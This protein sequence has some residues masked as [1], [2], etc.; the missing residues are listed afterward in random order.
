[1]KKVL[2]TGANG[3]LGNNLVRVLLKRGYQVKAGVRHMKDA[4]L[5]E[6]LTCE[7]VH[8]DLLDKG[9]LKEAL[10]GVEVLYQVAAVYKHW[11]CNPEEDIINANQ[12]GTKNILE[13]AKEAGVHQV[14]Y[15]S[16]V[17]ALEPT[18][19]NQNGQIHTDTWCEHNHNH[20]YI[21]SKTKSEKLAHKLSKELG[22]NL[23]A[24]LP[25]SMMGGIYASK[26]TPTANIC[27]S[28]VNGTTGFTFDSTI[29]P[30]CVMDVA[31]AMVDASEVG[32]PG[33]RYILAPERPVTFDRMFEI[34]KE[35][36]PNL[37]IPPK[38]DYSSLIQLAQ[39][40][41]EEAL[42]E[43]IE[44]RLQVCNINAYYGLE[45]HY[46]I[47]ASRKD[48]GFVYKKPETVLRDYFKL[49][50]HQKEAFYEA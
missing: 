39:K 47:E 46:D 15:V 38:L 24:V 12:V 3:H 10:D 36:N 4:N 16:S 1:M 7:L 26:K 30:I 50:C 49:L 8:A 28:V 33:K 6:G 5:F 13:A 2:V 35:V 17:V 27:S 37:V 22:L 32:V 41:E 44:P 43:G 45:R 18:E 25:G 34:A 11:S 23:I 48:L 20:P 31:E 21:I 9:S 14:I 19:R 29:S 42:A 40:I